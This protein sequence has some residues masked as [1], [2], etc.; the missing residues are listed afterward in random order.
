MEKRKDGKV[1]SLILCILSSFACLGR[2]KFTQRKRMW[3]RHI[4]SLNLILACLIL[5]HLEA[6][7]MQNSVPS[8]LVRC[9]KKDIILYRIFVSPTLFRPLNALPTLPPL[10]FSKPNKNLNHPS[11]RSIG[12]AECLRAID[13]R[14]RND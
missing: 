13:G 8:S 9:K 10:L 7:R 2:K 1:G 14:L 6:S 3:H 4:V 12:W 5:R 11:P